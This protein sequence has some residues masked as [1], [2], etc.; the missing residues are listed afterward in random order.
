MKFRAFK[1]QHKLV[2]PEAPADI[3]LICCIRREWHRFIAVYKLFNPDHPPDIGVMNAG[4]NAE[5]A[6]IRRI[7][8]AE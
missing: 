3:C 8:R 6:G 4:S 7:Q 1:T 5:L 2:W